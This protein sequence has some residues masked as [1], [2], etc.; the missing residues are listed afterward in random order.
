[1]LESTEIL[2]R[3]SASIDLRLST[4]T[5]TK[6]QKHLISKLASCNYV[7]ENGSANQ[8]YKCR[9]HW[10]Y[11]VGLDI[12]GQISVVLELLSKQLLNRGFQQ[13][14]LASNFVAERS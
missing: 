4:T 13:S 5:I 14:W 6:I 2:S 12:I 3:A 11:S 8:F 7:P 1:M 10:V 9:S